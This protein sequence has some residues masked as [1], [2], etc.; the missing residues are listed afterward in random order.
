MNFFGNGQPVSQ[1]EKELRPLLLDDGVHILSTFELNK[2]ASLTYS[3]LVCDDMFELMENIV[4]KPLEY[5]PMTIQKTLVAMKHVLIYG[6]EKCVNHAFGI[7]KFVENLTKFNT[8]LA[9]QQQQGAA[10]FWQRLQGGGVDKGGPVREAA[11]AVCQLLSNINELQRIRTS[12]ASQTSLVPVGDDKVAFVTDEI[13]HY[14]LNK[15][16]EEQKRI[17]ITSNLSNSEGG[18]GGGYSAKDGKNVVGAAHGIDAMIKMANFEK[19]KF[20]DDGTSGPSLEETILQ[21]LAAEAAAQKAE[22]AEAAAAR[23]IDILGSSFNPTTTTTNAGPV[24]LLDFGDYGQTSAPAN[25]TGDIFGGFTTP[26]PAQSDD[27]LGLGGGMQQGDFLNMASTADSTWLGGGGQPDS[28][29]GMTY[30][31]SDTTQAVDPFAPMLATPTPTSPPTADPPPMDPYL[32][33]SS[34]SSA[35]GGATSMMNSMSMGGADTSQK[36]PIMGSNEDRFAALDAL[37]TTAQPKVTMLDA[38]LAENRIMGMDSSSSN[39]SLSNSAGLSL[40]HAP[41]VPTGMPPVPPSE[42]P[43]PPS[44][45]TSMGMPTA[46]PLDY[47]PEPMGMLPSGL[48]VT[49]G[50]G[51]VAANY[52]DAN[53]DDDEDNPWV[54]GGTAGA[55]LQPMAPAP[56]APPPPLPPS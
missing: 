22:A 32:A 50:S 45:Y 26:A 9:S 6:S 46:P 41:P 43:L 31:A 19:K 48:M 53:D 51:H 7:G 5:S 29:L 12:S 3:D 18:F 42:P 55:G 25:A 4:G 13:R 40:S 47:P 24:D 49:P 1:A 2:I 54:M 38:K 20:S 21:E 10:A 17:H 23:N 33:A 35:L 52:G 8:F 56:G 37:A 34:S 16:I 28:L 44:I 36:R 39:A 15:K 11:A 14:L 30:T 27:L